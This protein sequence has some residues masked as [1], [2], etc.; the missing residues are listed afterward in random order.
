VST[1]PVI[2][3]DKTYVVFDSV[4]LGPGERGEIVLAPDRP[5][6]DPCVFMS[7]RDCEGV[8]V[9][10][11]V[12]GRTVVAR[13]GRWPVELFRNGHQLDGLV[14]SDSPLKVVVAN[15]GT[16]KISVGASLVDSKEKL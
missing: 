5:M 13:N 8:V 10:E 12:V 14:T 4:V 6:R 9:E 15:A 3:S 11:V 2:M 1:A 7:E 16:S